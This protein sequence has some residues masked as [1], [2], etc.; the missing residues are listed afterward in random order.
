MPQA[1]DMTPGTFDPAPST[2]AWKQA[3]VLRV[4]AVVRVGVAASTDL[5]ARRNRGRIVVV[6]LI[7]A[8]NYVLAVALAPVEVAL[9]LARRARRSADPATLT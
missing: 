2:V 4:H 1:L 8:C 5:F 3:H 9:S 7:S 6:V